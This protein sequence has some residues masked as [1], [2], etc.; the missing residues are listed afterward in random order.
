[1]DIKNFIEGLNEIDDKYFDEAVPKSR[2]KT[3]IIMKILRNGEW[4][5]TMAGVGIAACI[6]ITFSLFLFNNSLLLENANND[7]YYVD[8]QYGNT[9]G[10][11]A[12]GGLVAF[13][14]EWIYYNEDKSL[15][16]IRKNNTDKTKINGDDVSYL[17]IVGEWIYYKNNNDEKLYKVQTNGKNREKL[18]EYLVS[19]VNVASDWIYYVTQRSNNIHGTPTGG[20]FK[21]RLDGTENTNLCDGEFAGSDSPFVM[22]DSPY[23]LTVAD[24]W[25]YYVTANISRTGDGVTSDIYKMRL[26]GSDKTRIITH[27]KL[28]I[29]N[30]QI[31]NDR[32]Y[33]TLKE[34]LTIPWGYS[35]KENSTASMGKNHGFY[36]IKTNGVK[37]I[38]Y[39]KNIQ[40]HPVNVENGWI[41]YAVVN[42]Q[43]SI[44]HKMKTDGT[45]SEKL[46]DDNIL[47]LF[48][49]NDWIY[50][51]TD[52]SLYKI[53][54][55]GTNRTKIEDTASKIISQY[56]SYNT[57]NSKKSNNTKP[58]VSD[59]SID[60]EPPIED[61]PED[62]ISDGI[63]GNSNANYANGAEFTF[64]GEWIYYGEPTD[65]YKLY[66]IRENGDDKTQL[67]DKIHVRNLNVLNGWVYYTTLDESGLFKVRTNGKS[68][69]KIYN[70]YVDS[71]KVTGNYIYFAD[72][73]KAGIYRMKTNG[74]EITNLTKD[75]NS[76]N[77]EHYRISYIYDSQ[78]Y[79]KVRIGSKLYLYKI[80]T[81]GTENTE[82]C[83]FSDFAVHVQML[84]NT[85]Y[86]Y[87]YNE[88]TIYKINIDGVNETAIIN[89]VDI[90]AM[91]I[92]DDD[93]YYFKRIVKTEETNGTEDVGVYLYK[94][95]I[96]GEDNIR[97]ADDVI[98]S[99]MYGISGDWI[100][101]V[102]AEDNEVYRIK[103]DGTVFVV[104][105]ELI[106]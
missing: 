95:K 43:Y 14:D 60:T 49:D 88:K 16:K 90:A 78:I 100:Y 58:K 26:D 33:Y 3:N 82:I 20:I 106:Q 5:S 46:S 70:N 55:D 73:T 1:M 81:N 65:N 25:I 18:S 44:L 31:S 34:N 102:N 69:T 105:G 84:N 101:Y 83:R 85:I 21:M 45:K 67:S 22:T 15:Y 92:E 93:I 103:T 77:T 27:E 9:S 97:V 37:E 38:E 57:N 50:Y 80:K 75:K 104:R 11:H 30:F 68:E 74:K 76:K 4:G 91:F 59:V 42:K 8:G 35:I 19:T 41:Y 61:I 10:N 66:K 72:D 39:P 62:I 29:H 96:N 24:G 47:S 89:D 64:D 36:Q 28:Y 52:N 13:D 17:N 71:V 12:N 98:N 32:I 99:Y 48:I 53:K 79:Y 7:D 87:N 23:N 6:L 51:Y 40:I 63:F 86:Y 2:N 94:I 54:I 56:P